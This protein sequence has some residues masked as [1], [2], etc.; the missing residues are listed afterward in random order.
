MDALI[1][2]ESA[3]S[4]ALDALAD[5]IVKVATCSGDPK[6]ARAALKTFRQQVPTENR[7]D[8]CMFM[9]NE[10]PPPTDDEIEDGLVEP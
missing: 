3:Q 5:A 1:N 7:F 6:V 2:I 10:L 9:A 4:V 8:N